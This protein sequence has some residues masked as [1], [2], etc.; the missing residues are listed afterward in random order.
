MAG[1]G[2]GAWKVAYADFVTAMMSFFL[3]M[4]ILGQSKDVREAVAQYFKDPFHPA[5]KT[6]GASSPLRTKWQGVAPPG[7]TPRG[8]RARGRAFAEPGPRASADEQASDL[9]G[10][11][12]QMFVLHDGDHSSVGTVVPFAE[13]S[14]ELSDE[15]RRRLKR[16]AP[17]LVGKPNKIE[18]RGHSSRRPLPAGGPYQDAWQLCYARC[19]AVMKCLEQEGVKP[20]RMRLSQAGVYEPQTLRVG[21]GVQEQNSRVEVFALDELAENFVGTREERAERYQTP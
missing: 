13:G 19:Q 7:K 20:S 1:K 5:W 14:A 8:P 18:I 17:M 11:N 4:W 10:R 3:V 21:P 12:A 9:S 6:G 16:L 2:G 15:G